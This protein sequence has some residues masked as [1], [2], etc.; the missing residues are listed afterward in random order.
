LSGPPRRHA[1]NRRSNTRRPQPGSGRGTRH[2]DCHELQRC[3]STI[4]TR[5]KNRCQ[6]RRQAGSPGRDR[7][8]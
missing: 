1:R 4:R 6:S 5:E 8:R 2:H 7:S 3:P